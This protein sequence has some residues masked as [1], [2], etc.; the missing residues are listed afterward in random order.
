MEGLSPAKSVMVGSKAFISAGLPTAALLMQLISFR[1]RLGLNTEPNVRFAF[2]LSTRKYGD[3]DGKVGESFTKL[4]GVKSGCSGL[5]WKSGLDNESSPLI[6]DDP[7]EWLN[8][9]CLR[10]RGGLDKMD[11]FW[12]NP[13]LCLPF[14][15][16]CEL[17][18]WLWW[19]LLLLSA[20]PIDWR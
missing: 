6:C 1:L 7:F 13:L 9:E 18:L 19:P 4:V 5:I 3:E 10:G 14:V 2:L 16:F 20:M 15:I 12:S 17:M 8:S 11:L